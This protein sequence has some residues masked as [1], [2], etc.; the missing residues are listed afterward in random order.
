[1]EEVFTVK[2]R[3]SSSIVAA[4]NDGKVW[5]VKTTPNRK[6]EDA[7]RKRS[8]LPVAFERSVITNAAILAESAYFR[9]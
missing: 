9:M 6:E 1:M 2:P 3:G 7:M 8:L 4:D 5:E